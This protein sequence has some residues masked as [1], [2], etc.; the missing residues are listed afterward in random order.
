MRNSRYILIDSST[1][2]YIARSKFTPHFNLFNVICSNHWFFLISFHFSFLSLSLSP[3]F[4]C[5]F[6]LFFFALSFHWNIAIYVFLFWSLFINAIRNWMDH[7]KYDV[8]DEL[9]PMFTYLFQ[10]YRQYDPVFLI[11]KSLLL[12]LILLF[13]VRSVVSPEWI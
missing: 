8:N 12:L 2:L 1:S 9:E 13:F 4:N 5:F 6:F 11:L 3:S 7:L 10:C